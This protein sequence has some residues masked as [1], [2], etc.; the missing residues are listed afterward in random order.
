MG[1][2]CAHGVGAMD[3]IDRA[4]KATL[5]APSKRNLIAEHSTS[6]CEI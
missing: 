5:A 1:R 2:L 4:A 6:I 3:V